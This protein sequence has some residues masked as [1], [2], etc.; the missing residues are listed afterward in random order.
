MDDVAYLTIPGDHVD[1]VTSTVLGLYGARAEALGAS[2]LAYLDGREEPHPAT[3]F[4]GLHF[5]CFM[6][7]VEVR[8]M[9]ATYRTYHVDTAAAIAD[10]GRGDVGEVRD[11]V[12][13][14]SDRVIFGTDLLR[15]EV[16][17]MP[18]LGPRRWDLRE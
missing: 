7:W 5:G 2:A 10:M 13:D 9:L 12:V 18:D 1:S 15:T 4:V 8:R 14:F 17:E 3:H 11:I 16:I 6:S